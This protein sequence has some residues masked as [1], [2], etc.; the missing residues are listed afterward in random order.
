MVQKKQKRIEYEIQIRGLPPEKQ[1]TIIRKI[2]KRS[3][4]VKLV[5][6]TD[7]AYPLSHML[8][9]YR[10]YVSYSRIVRVE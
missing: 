9:Y 8:S 6:L 5:V 4:I 10:P 1:F 2:L 7:N 3:E